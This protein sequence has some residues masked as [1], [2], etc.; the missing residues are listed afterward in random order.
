MRGRKDGR[1]CGRVEPTSKML[2]CQNT[3]SQQVLISGDQGK[4]WIRLV[5]KG[6]SE[7]KLKREV[8]S[9]TCFHAMIEES[10]QGKQGSPRSLSS[11]EVM[12][13]VL[14][15]ILIY[16]KDIFW[17]SLPTWLCAGHNERHLVVLEKY[18]LNIYCFPSTMRTAL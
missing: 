1:H 13:S 11:A 7:R 5:V 6:W 2:R 16:S 18:L 9:L 3:K 15:Q 10:V 12:A 14:E 4:E 8:S 17:V